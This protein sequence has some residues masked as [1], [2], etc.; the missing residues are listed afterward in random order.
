MIAAAWAALQSRV[1]QVAAALVAVLAAL[2][3]AYAKGRQSA[4]ERAKARA[5]EEEQKGR[6]RADAAAA[7]AARDDVA[8]RLRDGRF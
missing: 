3:I 8:D 6:R 2:G 1:G 4:T 5:A 7:D